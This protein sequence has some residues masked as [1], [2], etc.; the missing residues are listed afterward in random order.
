MPGAL[1]KKR[2]P[3]GNVHDQFEAFETALAPKKRAH[4]SKDAPPGRAG[5]KPCLHKNRLASSQLLNVLCGRLE[6][7]SKCDLWQKE[8]WHVQ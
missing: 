6:A 5:L 2:F 4:G 7:Q 1:L 8:E 3:P